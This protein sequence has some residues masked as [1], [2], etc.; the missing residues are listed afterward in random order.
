MKTLTAVAICCAVAFV[1]PFVFWQTIEIK[2]CVAAL[3]EG[4]KGIGEAP[5]F[6]KQLAVAAV[7]AEINC[8]EK[9]EA[10]PF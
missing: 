4:T 6:T 5:M 9:E 2:F 8:P 10:F 7:N 3:P 1:F